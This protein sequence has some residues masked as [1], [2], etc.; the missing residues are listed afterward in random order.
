MNVLVDK[1]NKK[2]NMKKI[3]SSILVGLLAVAGAYG[4]SAIISTNIVAGAGNHLIT[5]NRAKVYAIETTST[6]AVS[7][8][9]FDNDNTTSTGAS[10]ANAGF[11]GTNVVTGAYVSRV[12][13]PTNYAVAFTNNYGLAYTNTYT[14]IWTLNVTNAAATNAMSPLVSVATGGAESRVTYT[15]AIFTRGI[16]LGSSGNGNI[17]V[18][19]RVDGN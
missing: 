5:T 9:F 3:L 2:G 16:V 18:Y 11:W 13:Y 1:T 7:Y 19:Y 6:N 12:S 4:Q 15:D 10:L 17:T 8:R 14:G